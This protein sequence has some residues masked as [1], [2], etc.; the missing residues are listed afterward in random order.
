MLQNVSTVS[1]WPQRIALDELTALARRKLGKRFLSVKRYSYG[2][3]EQV[4]VRA[5]GVAYDGQRYFKRIA[6]YK[7]AA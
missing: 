3:G 6:C 1:T 7:D 5:L 4:E 2:G